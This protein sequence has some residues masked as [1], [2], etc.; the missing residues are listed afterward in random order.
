ME[1]EEWEINFGA[2]PKLPEGY[3]VM[4]S[5]GAEH[6][7][8]LGPDGVEIGFS[9]NRFDVRREVVA[10]A[11]KKIIAAMPSKCPLTGLPFFMPIKHPD[12][13]LVPTFGGPFDSY[14]TPEK[15]EGDDSYFWWR[16]DHDLGGWTGKEVV[17]LS[18]FK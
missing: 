13:G 9:W 3:R 11:K 14:T 4:W 16:F 12:L 15:D 8:G 7:F 10:Y 17:D 6:Y 5:N 18:D 1:I 2:L